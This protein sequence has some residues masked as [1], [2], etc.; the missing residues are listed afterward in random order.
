[1]V[2]ILGILANGVVW[3]VNGASKVRKRNVEHQMRERDMLSYQGILRHWRQDVLN[4]QISS[5]NPSH[6][7]KHS[8]EA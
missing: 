7:A 2:S 4:E 3:I 6:L 1:V 5:A 8:L